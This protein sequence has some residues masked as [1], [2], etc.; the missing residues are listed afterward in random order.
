MPLFGRGRQAPTRSPVDVEIEVLQAAAAEVRLEDGRDYRRTLQAWQRQALEFYDLLGEA[1]YPAQ[2]YARMLSRLR[3]HPAIELPNGEHE[4]V[5]DEAAQVILQRIQYRRWASTF[6]Q[7]Q[8]IVGDGYLAVYLDDDGQET[9]DYFSPAELIVQ[10]RSYLRRMGDG[11][12]DREYAKV[13]V[14]PEGGLE[15]AQMKSWRLWNRH[16]THSEMADSP[17]RAIIDRLSY[18]MH[19]DKAAFAA[20]LSRI[21]G[22]GIFIVDERITLPP[23]EAESADDD[24][25]DDPFMRRLM[26]YMLKPISTPGSAAQQAPRVARV[27]P[28]EGMAVKDMTAWIRFHDPN[29]TTDWESKVEKTIRRIAISL[30]MPPAELLGL[31]NANQWVG[32]LI[33]EDKWKAHGEPVADRLCDDLTRGYYRAACIAAGVEN[34]EKLV[35]WRDPAQVVV[36]PDHGKAA[37]E[38]HDRGGLSDKAL[39]A[40]HNFSE[41][42]GPSPAEREAWEIIKMKSRDRP[43]DPS[44][45]DARGSGSHVEA[46]APDNNGNRTNQPSP[47]ADNRQMRILGSAEIIFDRLRERAGTFL[48]TRKMQC[49]GCFDG[50]EGVPRGELAATVGQEVVRMLD[51]TSELALVAGGADVFATKLVKQ[52]GYD[53]HRAEVIAR[54]LERL[55]AERLYEPDASLPDDF[56]EVL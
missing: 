19:L 39:R 18:L 24:M 13:S 53:I 20:A 27:E 21:A 46:G 44:E 54:V 36:H 32:W 47:Q 11:V 56:L 55:A 4:E 38:V 51:V 12:P 37:E 17:M 10:E 29:Q 45:A 6:G 23:S 48:W 16:P 30:D 9:W 22:A 35:V 41:S 14:I 1:W 31:E 34:A 2:F 43:Q 7:L 15:V 3:L 5:E 28:P 50:M 26:S 52:W 40:A 33:G 8:A 25:N 42:D 49:E